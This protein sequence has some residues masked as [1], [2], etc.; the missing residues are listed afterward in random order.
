MTEA[1]WLACG[2]PAKML[3]SLQQ[4]A[5]DRK[6]RLFA[7]A[8]CRRI[9][10]LLIDERSR[11]LVDKVEAYA[12]G[13]VS[14]ID[15]SKAWNDHEHSF[16]A[17]ALK[18]PWCAVMACACDGRQSAIEAAVAGIG[19]ASESIAEDDPILPV[20][21]E[22]VRHS[23][24]I[25]QCHLLRDIFGPLHFRTVAVDRAWGT[26]TVTNLAQ[27]IYEDRAFDRLPILADALEDAGCTNA[28]VLNHC[29]GGGEHVRGCWVVDLLLGKD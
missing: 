23:E 17:Y 15:L 25:A 9:S 14:I 28:D 8:C 16:S 11:G 13:R 3:E 26:A 27:A 4:K 21:T 10:H 24:G 2:D 29:R 6:W 12:D 22:A 19:E 1:E 20:I 18:P 7:V 5:S